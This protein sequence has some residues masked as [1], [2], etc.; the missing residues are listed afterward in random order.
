MMNMSISSTPIN[1]A[2]L[3][4]AVACS[5]RQSSREDSAMIEKLPVGSAYSEN[6]QLLS[7]NG[8]LR[9]FGSP[10]NTGRHGSTKHVYVR[11]KDPSYSLSLTYNNACKLQSAEIKKR[12]INEL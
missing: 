11:G 2:L 10:C 12:E 7:E 6:H 1:I 4:L 9:V 3:A 8:W 5:S